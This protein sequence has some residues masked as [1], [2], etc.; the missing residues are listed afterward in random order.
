MS[1]NKLHCTSIV[2]SYS[3]LILLLFLDYLPEVKNCFELDHRRQLPPS[4]TVPVNY[5]SHNL[6]CDTSTWFI[7]E[8]FRRVI[9]TVVFN[10]GWS[11]CVMF[12]LDSITIITTIIINIHIVNQVTKSL[13]SKAWN[14]P[15]RYPIF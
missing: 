3:N 4:S 6:N 1:T 15:Q 11:Q 7:R 8:L 12:Q 5:I 10:D 14:L 2:P 13:L 9:Q